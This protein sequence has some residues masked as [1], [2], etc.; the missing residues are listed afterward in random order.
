MFEKVRAPDARFQDMTTQIYNDYK[1][2]QGYS[3]MEIISKSKALKEK[4]IPLAV[5]LI[6]NVKKSGIKDIVTIL[7]FVNFEVF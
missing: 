1:I 7:K 3:P 4:W 2:E 5:K 6:K